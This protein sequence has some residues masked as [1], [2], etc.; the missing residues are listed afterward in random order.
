MAISKKERSFSIWIGIAIGVALSSM[1]VRYAL[2]K[3]AE[4]TRDRPGNYQS[5]KCASDGSPFSP[6]P[7]AIRSQIPHGIVV[8]LKITKL[9][10]IQISPFRSSLGLLNPLDPSVQKDFSSWHRKLIPA[11]NTSFIVLLSFT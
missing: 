6:I 4:Q 10:M 7:D 3:K 1:L 11:Q 8:F 5:L 2:Q 9:P